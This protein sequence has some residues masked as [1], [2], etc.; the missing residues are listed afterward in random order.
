MFILKYFGFNENS[1]S[2]CC[3]NCDVNGISNAVAEVT[4]NS[5]EIQENLRS[6]SSESQSM[7]HDSLKLLLEEWNDMPNS[8]DFQ[9][10]LSLADTILTKAEFIKDTSDL[11]DNFDVWDEE[12][13][14]KIFDLILLFSK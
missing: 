4:L 8:F 12:L 11:F 14:V 10:D 9:F 5:N 7:L 1:Q 2:R 6:L 13:C 3:S